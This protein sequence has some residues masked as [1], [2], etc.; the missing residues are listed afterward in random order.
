[1]ED[2]YSFGTATTLQEYDNLITRCNYSTLWPLQFG[3]SG[4]K[5]KKL[6]TV[7]R[8]HACKEYLLQPSVFR[9]NNLQQENKLI[10]NYKGIIKTRFKKFLTDFDVIAIMQ[11]YGAPTRFL[12][13]SIDSRQALYFACDKEKEKDGQVILLRTNHVD[14]KCDEIR[15]LLALAQLPKNFGN[16]CDEL[17]EK[18][19]QNFPNMLLLQNLKRH[20]LVFPDISSERLRLQKG[21][22]VIFG[23]SLSKEGSKSCSSLF[24]AGMGIEGYFCCINIP[25]QAKDSILAELEGIGIKQD[26][27]YPPRLWME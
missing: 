15:T 3:L 2:K 6:S 11:H 5:Q 21:A 8:G 22:F 10:Q 20:Y 25:A 14:A 16:L 7:Y 23:E 18:M 1:M 24:D 19:N 9:N 12:D 17:R 27:V 26:T 4:E 13:F